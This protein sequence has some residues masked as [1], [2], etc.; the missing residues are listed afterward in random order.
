MRAPGC[1]LLLYQLSPSTPSTQN[2]WIAPASSF[3][4]SARII[5][6]SSYSKN[7]PM[8]VGNT[9][10]GSPAWPNTSD[11]MS[12][13]NSWLYC[14]LNSRF[15]CARIVT[16]WPG[17]RHLRRGCAQGNRI[18]P[19]WRKLRKFGGEKEDRKKSERKSEESLESYAG[20]APRRISAAYARN[21]FPD[22]SVSTAASSAS[23]PTSWR[24]L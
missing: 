4:A 6:A 12:R 7:R 10:I 13:P 3:P 14:R 20:F 23:V 2:S 15:I 16:D 8:D 21:E 18:Q 19:G 17:V 5:P 22:A 24:L 1:T 11:S 9:R